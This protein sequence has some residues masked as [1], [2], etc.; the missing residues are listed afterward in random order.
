MCPPGLHITLGIFY[1]LYT[2]LEEECHELDVMVK[3]Q[4]SQAGASY[5]RY[6]S[7]LRQ[8][9]TRKEDE[10]RL[11]VQVNGLEQLVTLLG[12]TLPNAASQPAYQQLCRQVAERR[13]RLKKVVN[14]TSKINV[15]SLINNH[16]C[17]NT[18]RGDKEIAGYPG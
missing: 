14:I 6:V 2:L 1:R 10:G 13:E 12:I 7:A 16:T 15:N 4:A 5:D 11:A 9:S 17:I 8:Q 3:F 18:E